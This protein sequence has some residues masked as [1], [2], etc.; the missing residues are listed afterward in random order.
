MPAQLHQAILIYITGTPKNILHRLLQPR[1]YMPTPQPSI[2][3]LSIMDLVLLQKIL[4]QLVFSLFLLIL[5]RYDTGCAPHVTL[6]PGVFSSYTYLWSTAAIT[7]TITVSSSGPYWVDVKNSHGCVTRDSAFVDVIPLATVTT[8]PQMVCYLDSLYITDATAA[9]YDSLRWTTTGD[10]HFNNSKLLNTIYKVG[11]NDVINTTV[12]LR[13]TAYSTCGSVYSTMVVYITTAPTVNAGANDTICR[14]NNVHLSASGGTTY[15]WSP[16]TGLSSISIAN[17]IADPTRTTTYT[18]TGT[19]SC[20]SA[21][22]SVK[23]VVDSI[24]APTLGPND[25]ICANNSQI[26]NAGAGYHTYLWSTGQV[27]QSITVDSATAH[28]GI[29]TLK[30]YVDVTK[31][32]CT[33]SDTIKITFDVCTG[34]AEYSNNASIS[35]FPNPT[36]GKTNIILNGITGSAVLDIYSILG[37]SVFSEN[38]NGN[39]KTELDLSNLPKGVYF[40]KVNNVKTS[41]LSKLIIQQTVVCTIK[42]P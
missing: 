12:T 3:L 1:P 23:V 18:V 27:G 17:P 22:A 13:L 36:T 2:L 4:Q 21:S 41:I 33:A 24:T 34:I 20:G 7:P 11:P 19:S 35:I 5:V 9:N 26:L 14:G 15:Q 39:N 42:S 32:A 40:V 29:G 25:T 10:G 31:G 28:T 16:S 38:V 6:N 37:Q 30:V 8:F